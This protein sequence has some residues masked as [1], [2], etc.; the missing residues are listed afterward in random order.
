[1]KALAI[2]VLVAATISWPA[3]GQ[4]AG[5]AAIMTPREFG[6][7]AAIANKFEVIES[8]LALRQASDRQLKEYAELMIKDHTVALEDLQAVA[9]A[10]GVEL[11][12]EI[13]PDAAHQ[14]KIHAIKNRRDADFDRAYRADQLEAHA[15]AAALLDAYAQSGGNAQL[16]AWAARNLPTVRKHLEQLQALPA[17][18]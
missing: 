8:L 17:S 3:S 6:L 5:A 16:K 7:N 2:V 9:H 13:A 12:A 18:P 10:A 15:D 4:P 1:M 11:P 14:A